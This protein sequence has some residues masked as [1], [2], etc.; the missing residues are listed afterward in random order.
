MKK[1]LL[2]F[3][4]TFVVLVVNAQ[5]M[6]TDPNIRQGKLS[7]GLTYYIQHNSIIK[8]RAEFYLA[9]KVGSIQEKDNQAGLAHFLE[10][11]AFK[12]TVN[13]PEK[14][15]ERVDKIG[16][17]LFNAYTS[18]DETVYY[19]TGIPVTSTGIV[20]TCLLILHDW[21]GF[22]SLKDDQIDEERNVIREEWRTRNSSGFRMSEKLFAGI[23]E[24]SKY[25][26]RM[27]IGK[28]DVINN[29]KYDELRDYYHEWYRPD[30]QG[31]IV[32][33]DIDVDYIE[34]KIKTMFADV[35]MPANP[36]ERVYYDVPD[37][38]EP[39][40]S[41]VTDP[42]ATSTGVEMYIKHDVIPHDH[43]D[44]KDYQVIGFVRSL[45]AQMLNARVRELSQ[46]PDAP[47]NGMSMGY[48][49]FVVAKSKDAWRA[50]ASAK[51]GKI[52]ETLEVIIRE[53]ERAKKH[54]FIDAEL[55]RAKAN[56]LK[57][58]ENAY[59][60]R[61]KQYNNAIVSPILSGFLSDEAIPGIENK[62]D[63]LKEVLPKLNLEIVNGF[64]KDVIADNN[65]ILAISGPE[66][67]G[68]VYPAKGELL[69]VIK[70][71]KAEN[72]T[73]YTESITD[74]P[75][76]S[77]L[78]AP[79]KVVKEEKGKLF[80][81]TIWTLSNGMKVVLKH[82]D[83]KENQILMSSTAYGGS[84][85]FP[86]ED[87]NTRYVGSMATVGG[88]GNFSR[89]DLQK[90][91]AGK[92][93]S[94]NS[95]ISRYTVGISGNS[96]IEDFE[97]MMQLAY[98]QFTSPRKDLDAYN[99]SIERIKNSLKNRDSE[100]SNIFNDSITKS[101]YG[102]NPI[103]KKIELSDIEKL[104]YDKMIAMYKQIF[105]NPGSFVFTFVGTIDEA[106]V[107]PLIEKYLG[108]L[109]SGDK[110]ATYKKVDLDVRKG[111]IANHFTQ[112]MA[113]PKASAFVYYSGNLG[114]RTVKLKYQGDMLKQILDLV[115]QRTMREEEGGTYG[116]R[117]AV[118]ISRIPEGETSIA[119]S[120]TT[121]PERIEGMNRVLHREIQKIAENGPT[122]E[123][124]NK[125]KE[126]LIKNR[127]EWQKMNG[128]WTAALDI[129]YFY[130]EDENSDYK[131]LINSISKDDIK[132]MMKDLTAQGNV[133]EVVMLP[134]ED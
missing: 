117:T 12:S 57:S 125:A 43:R 111:K 87:I 107:K 131:T 53:N 67:E 2:L 64:I 98:L 114:K 38:K 88:V 85:L 33:G 71:V 48:G 6:P 74:G 77:N 21:C 40:V 32:V 54:G 81:E 80:N 11:M 94:A 121:D 15:S 112:A 123:D 24:G 25:A 102:N 17:K 34:N 95:Y 86:A 42:E 63:L 133:I 90:V 122:D 47:F 41:I 92:T 3:L 134:K 37:N 29:F 93:A 78:P 97:T 105:A 45:V 7:N 9:Q 76:V 49:S 119:I 109:P 65:I 82:T 99:S 91:L 104:D 36:T 83:F 61:N 4:L 44:T 96:T 100:P 26:D 22:I 50:S 55:E 52:K 110:N 1:H 59:N 19:L 120:Y 106:K 20:D 56:L 70:K 124:Y 129:L 72:I 75:L 73:P 89:T 27:P 126:Y 35:K 10:H 13:F 68:L 116:V 18:F 127:D 62:Y 30:L 103:T 79:G 31:I 128:F 113:V 23:Y 39:I 60:N 118:D 115:Y 108:A 51:E 28:I 66:K 14:V 58:Y 5:Q 130:G 132:Q 46:K 16:S 101:L 69:D 8:E 84:S